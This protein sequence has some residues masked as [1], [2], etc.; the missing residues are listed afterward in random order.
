MKAPVKIRVL[1]E[2]ES[3]GIWYVTPDGGV[4]MLEHEDINLPQELSDKFYQ[5]IALYF[6]RLTPSIA[7]VWDLDRFNNMGRQIAQDLKNFV[8]AEVTVEYVPELPSDKT[9]QP[10]LVE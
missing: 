4:G 1:A 2:Y 9:G 6:G 3:S 10:E 8:G 7:A 5:W